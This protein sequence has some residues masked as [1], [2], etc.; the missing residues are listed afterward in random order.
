MRLNESGH[1]D[2]V[3]G[4]GARN[5]GALC[6]QIPF[7]PAMRG[8]GYVVLDYH[9]EPARVRFGYLDDDTIRQ[10][11]ADYPAPPDAERT[12]T[13]STEP[14]TV[15]AQRD[16]NRRH[17]YRPTKRAAP[18]LPDSLLNVLNPDGSGPR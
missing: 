11:A 18:L 13:A 9:P 4:D 1:V 15:P 12:T 8:T 2:L 6:D 7:D 14:A 5:R 10:M 3:L 17:T 16:S